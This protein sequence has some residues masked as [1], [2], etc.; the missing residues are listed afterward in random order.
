M[1]GIHILALFFSSLLACS[2]GFTIDEPQQ[3]SCQTKDDCE[4]LYECKAN[5]CVVE[6]PPNEDC[7]DVDGDGFGVGKNRSLC[8]QCRTSAANGAGCIEDFD[9]ADETRYPGAPEL[10][11]G[12][13]N[14]NDGNIDNTET[15]VGFEDDVPAEDA[16]AK[17][18]IAC[19][20]ANDCPQ[21]AQEGVAS[22]CDQASKKCVARMTISIG[23]P[24]CN[25]N[26]LICTDGSYPAVP[27]ACGGPLQ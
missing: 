16:L 25:S 19:V 13:D 11:D 7:E 17:R 2:V 22:L 5:I 1:K 8:P 12:K 15:P 23:D 4:A 20:S 24:E 27:S 6:K 9:D 21:S 3:F 10:C 18:K 26:D 14:D